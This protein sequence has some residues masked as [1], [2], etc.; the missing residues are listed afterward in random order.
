MT[1]LARQAFQF[2]GHSW[3]MLAPEAVPITIRYSDLIA[4]RLAGL[5]AVPGW[6]ADAVRFGHIGASLWFL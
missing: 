3:R 5:S 1:Y 4:Q 6:D 2:S